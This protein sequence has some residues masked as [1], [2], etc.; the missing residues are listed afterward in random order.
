MKMLLKLFEPILLRVPLDANARDPH[1]DLKGDVTQNQAALG[2][3]DHQGTPSLARVRLAE[4][5]NNHD[6]IDLVNARSEAERAKR[7]P[8]R[9]AFQV[10]AI[11]MPHDS[12]QRRTNAMVLQFDGNL[13]QNL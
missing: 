12:L 8:P 13:I 11:R 3:L 5:C 7:Q 6:M 1:V 4:L 2:D 10:I 9:D